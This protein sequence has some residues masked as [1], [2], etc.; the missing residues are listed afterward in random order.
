MS[1]DYLKQ[2][3]S[4]QDLSFE[5]ARDM[6]QHIFNNGFTPVK[7]GAILAALACKGESVQEISAA[8]TVMRYKMEK[9]QLPEGTSFKNRVID[10]CGTGGDG[11]NSFNI[12]TTVAFV[13]AAAGVNVAKHGNR[14]VSSYSGSSDVLT[15]LGVNLEYNNEQAGKFLADIGLTFLFAPNFHKALKPIA[16]IRKD[17]GVRTI[18]N[19]LGP[20]CNPAQ[21]KYQLIGVYDKSLCLKICEVMRNTGSEEVCV[22]SS[23]DGLDELSVCDISYVA[24]L[25]GSKIYEYE[26]DPRVYFGNFHKMDELAGGDSK[27]NARA[28][29]NILSPNFAQDEDNAYRN[30][31]ILNSALAL[32]IADYVEDLNSGVEMARHLIKSG[33]AREKM[34]QLVEITNDSIA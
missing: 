1:V 14:A 25:K 26:V 23:R 15:E 34:R 19:I 8:T 32:L 4:G 11:K 9:L 24:H 18:F 7:V 22:V 29:M 30:A 31:V 10:V 16:P 5:D 12:S 3:I 21:V 13:V 20:L 6:F 27:K 2:I 33:K 17:M 28:L